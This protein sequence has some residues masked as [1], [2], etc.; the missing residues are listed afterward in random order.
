MRRKRRELRDVN[1]KRKQ[2]HVS[3]EALRKKKK[4][5]ATKENETFTLDITTSQLG[6]NADKSFEQ[7]HA[8]CLATVK[9]TLY[10]LKPI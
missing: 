6:K 9:S 8:K 5:Q 1:M 4:K 10:K 7:R 3:A 2:S